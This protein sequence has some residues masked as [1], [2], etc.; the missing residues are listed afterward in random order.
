MTHTNIICAH[1]T[2]LCE[3]AE[4]GAFCSDYCK[5]AWDDN[6]TDAACRCGHAACEKAQ[7]SIDG[8]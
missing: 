7:D 1:E 3:V 8:A 5:E 6:I 2:C 4:Q